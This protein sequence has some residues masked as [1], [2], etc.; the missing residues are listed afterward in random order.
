MMRV[1]SRK[2]PQ[3]HQERQEEAPAKRREGWW[4]KIDWF[5]WIVSLAIPIV[6]GFVTGIL[7][8]NA[9]RDVYGR[10]DLP[11]LAPDQETYPI[12]WSIL[13]VLMGIGLS[14]AW[15]AEGDP[16]TRRR[17]FTAFGVQLALTAAW[18]IVFFLMESFQAAVLIVLAQLIATAYT[19]DQFGRLSP[20]AG[21]VFL[22]QLLW[23]AFASYLNISIALLN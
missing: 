17:A 10:I 15:G 6:V 12:V 19:M 22:P 2:T 1:T 20:W 9:A 18:P 23:V 8:G 3:Q 7:T 4:S 11:P 16:K 5:R 14:L 21:R 13:Y